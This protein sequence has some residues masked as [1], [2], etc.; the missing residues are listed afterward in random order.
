VSGIPEFCREIETHLCKKNDGHL[1]RVVGP[2]FDLVSAWAERGIPLKVALAGID[3]YFERYYR[4]GPRRRPVKID[5]CEADVLD[6]FDE[7][8][9]ATGVTAA[10]DADAETIPHPARQSSLPEHLQRVL[11]RLTAA[12]A[13]GTIGGSFDATIDQVAEALDD[14]R[15]KAGGVRGDARRAVL[16]RLASL[17]HAMMALA[18]T[19]LDP[20]ALA[21]AEHE[22]TTELAPFKA[23]MADDAYA[24]AFSAAVDQVIRTRLNLPTIGF[25]PR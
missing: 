22:A 21:T 6:V 2:S 20:K 19:H 17:D 18:R 11:T 5:F 9:R 8:R 1:I 13:S 14:V 25:E 10:T 16:D 24:R 7:W 15:Q 12:R 23:A 3:R 4:R